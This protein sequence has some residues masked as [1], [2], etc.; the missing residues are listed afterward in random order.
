M[1]HPIDVIRSLEREINAQ[2]E[3]LKPMLVDQSRSL[4]ERWDAFK[5]VAHLMPIGPWSSHGHLE[6]IG[7]DCPY[8]HGFERRETSLFEYMYDNF[9]GDLEYCES[10]EYT[11]GYTREQLDTW[12]EAILAS[13]YGGFTYGW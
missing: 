2:F 12:R 8:D 1:F 9:L 4:D 6:L 13:G 5:Q 3:L 7:I 11:C 10:A